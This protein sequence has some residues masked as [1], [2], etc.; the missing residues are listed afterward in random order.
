MSM[1]V[2]MMVIKQFRYVIKT[3]RDYSCSS[4]RTRRRE[5]ILIIVVVIS[6]YC[7]W[8]HGLSADKEI[9]NEMRLLHAKVR[10]D[11]PNLDLAQSYLS[12]W[13]LGHEDTIFVTARLYIIV[14]SKYSSISYDFCGMKDDLCC[15][16]SNDI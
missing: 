2:W 14:S 10:I 16:S 3:R 6:E 13:S 9:S 1:A 5:Y 7:L 4:N 15:V 8:L 11:A 12:C